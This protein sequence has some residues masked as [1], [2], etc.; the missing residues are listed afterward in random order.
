MFILGQKIHL[1]MGSNKPAPYASELEGWPTLNLASLTIHTKSCQTA[2]A[3]TAQVMLV[4]AAGAWYRPGKLSALSLVQ[5]AFECLV[6]NFLA[7]VD[8]LHQ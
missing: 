8:V 4:R 2:V 3:S 1:Q 5:T 7:D 6:D